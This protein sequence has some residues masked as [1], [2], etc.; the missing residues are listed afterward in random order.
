MPAN[1]PYPG[2]TKAAFKK[3]MEAKPAFR[4]KRHPGYKPE[5]WKEHGS[6]WPGGMTME[7]FGYRTVRSEEG[8]KPKRR[9]R[10]RDAIKA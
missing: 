4:P 1:S 8:Q 7:E 10:L 6:A 9:V 2:E 5:F 3:R